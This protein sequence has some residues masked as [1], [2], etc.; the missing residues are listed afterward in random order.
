MLGNAGPHLPKSGWLMRWSKLSLQLIPRSPGGI[1]TT[2]ITIVPVMVAYIAFGMTGQMTFGNDVLTRTLAELAATPLAVLAIAYAMNRI[3]YADIGIARG[4]AE[5]FHLVKPLMIRAAIIS[6]VLNLVIGILA[7]VLAGDGAE[8]VA[9]GSEGRVGMGY[10]LALIYGAGAIETASA[11]LPLAMIHP[12]AIPAALGIGLSMDEIRR[13]DELLKAKS[14][15]TH[16]NLFM[17][18]GLSPILASLVPVFLMPPVVLFLITWNYVG[19]REVIGG[20]NG[21]G[22]GAPERERGNALH[23][24]GSA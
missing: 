11:F 4:M 22:Q 21:N 17:A 7:A 20:I 24:A 2:A 5:V 9:S 23:A 10:A 8:Q 16:F 18:T 12:F 14:Y 3:M 15:S 19:G 1:V 13:N 6:F